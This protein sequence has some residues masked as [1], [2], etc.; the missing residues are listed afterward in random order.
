MPEAEWFASRKK[1][2]PTGIVSWFLLK[3]WMTSLRLW[4]TSVKLTL[5]IK[6]S[7]N[8]IMRY[9]TAKSAYCNTFFFTPAYN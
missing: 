2:V 5:K 9:S 4:R 1:S 7:N 6:A 8:G 3:F